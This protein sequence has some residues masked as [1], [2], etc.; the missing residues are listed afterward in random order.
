LSLSDGYWHASMGIE[1]NA[2][3][4]YLSGDGRLCS[5]LELVG[6]GTPLA[7]HRPTPGGPNGVKRQGFVSARRRLASSSR[8]PCVTSEQRIRPPTHGRHRHGTRLPVFVL[9]VTLAASPT[10]PPRRPRSS[11][12]LSACYSHR[13]PL[14]GLS[15]ERPFRVETCSRCASA[16]AG[17]ALPPSSA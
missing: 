13:H 6:A 15:L 17:G 12:G 7:G 16:R 1:I 11:G 5:A 8:Q 14:A 3:N 2:L 4:D 9:L 10:C